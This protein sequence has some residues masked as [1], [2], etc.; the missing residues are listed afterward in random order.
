[1]PPATTL[2]KVAAL[3]ACPSCG[4]KDVE[5][6]APAHSVCRPIQ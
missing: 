4:G 5:I 2:A 3:M 6:E 1:L